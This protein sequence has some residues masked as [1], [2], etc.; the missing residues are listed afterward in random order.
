MSKVVNQSRYAIS[1]ITRD[2]G[3]FASGDEMAIIGVAECR[4]QTVVA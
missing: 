2:N 1:A 4:H 3:I